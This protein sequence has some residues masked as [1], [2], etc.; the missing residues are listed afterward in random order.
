VRCEAQEPHPAQIRSGTQTASTAAGAQVHGL[1]ESSG[2][3]STSTV[4]GGSEVQG[5]GRWVAGSQAKYLQSIAMSAQQQTMCGGCRCILVHPDAA[6][7]CQS[8]QSC[9]KMKACHAAICWLLRCDASLP[10]AGKVRR[11]GCCS[12]LRSPISNQ[13]HC[14]DSIVIHK[15]SVMT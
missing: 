9:C 1:T 13:H 10:Q 2:T 14:C 15:G 6:P 12:P 11:V 7:M 8:K 5:P 4:H 3:G